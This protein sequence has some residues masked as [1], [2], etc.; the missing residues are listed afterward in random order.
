MFSMDFFDNFSLSL[1]LSLSLFY[2]RARARALSLSLSDLLSDAQVLTRS[3]TFFTPLSRAH[4][5][6]PPLVTW[7]VSRD[8]VQTRD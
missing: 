7:E 1:V 3:L 2:A 8:C 4:A 5:L 6:L